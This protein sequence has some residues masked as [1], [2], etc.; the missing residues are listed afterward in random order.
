M[1]W[2]VSGTGDFNGDGK[3]DILWR[4]STTALSIAPWPVGIMTLK[5]RT[6]TP[7]V[8]A[9]HRLRARS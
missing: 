4:D 2:A 9:L 7:A 6:L 8:K 5:N 3:S 1:P